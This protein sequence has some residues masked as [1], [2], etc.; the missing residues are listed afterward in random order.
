MFV[1]TRAC[2]SPFLV[3]Y[4][5]YVFQIILLRRRQRKRT[6]SLIEYMIVLR[7]GNLR[8]VFR[9]L[10]LMRGQGFAEHETNNLKRA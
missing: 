9:L 6:Y 2:A 3:Y 1:L 10:S 5:V 7:Q 8:Q 4:S